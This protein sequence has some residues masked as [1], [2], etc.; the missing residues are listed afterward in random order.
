MGLMPLPWAFRPWTRSYRC[1]VRTAS[2]DSAGCGIDRGLLQVSSL[3]RIGGGGLFRFFGNG[4]FQAGAVPGRGL[5]HVLAQVVV[6]VPPV[7]DLVSA[8]RALPGAV[9][10]GAGPVTAYHLDPGMFLQP[11]RD[12]GGLPVA[13]QVNGP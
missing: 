1:R 7:G 13:E 10:V 12:G 11:V 5:V 8:G 3:P 4:F 2:A 6:D 9:G